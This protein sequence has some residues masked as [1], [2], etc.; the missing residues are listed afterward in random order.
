LRGGAAAVARCLINAFVSGK[1]PP[2]GLQ[3]D[4]RHTSSA[5]F[6]AEFLALSFFDL[7]IGGRR[8]LLLLLLLLL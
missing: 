5:R 6:P 8:L 7:D 4:V 3:E 1:A 2:S